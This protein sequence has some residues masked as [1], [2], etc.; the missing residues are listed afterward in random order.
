VHDNGFEHT[1]RKGR[2]GLI[3]KEG[4][5]KELWLEYI[6]RDSIRG[7]EAELE[8]LLLHDEEALMSYTEALTS[9]EHEIPHLS[10][11]L[12]FKNQVMDQILLSQTLQTKSSVK[13]KKWSSH[14]LFHYIIAASVTLFLLSSGLFD[15]LSQGTN[16]I[17]HNQDSHTLSQQLLEKTT[18][19]I[20]FLKP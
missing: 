5:H 20:N 16:Q 15:L 8:E 2:K 12:R 10:D 7:N 3:K 4:H 18:G 1:G 9:L 13:G 6:T 11:E 14:P 17:I 19:W